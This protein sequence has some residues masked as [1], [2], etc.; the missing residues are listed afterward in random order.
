MPICQKCETKFPNR[1]R[2]DGKLKNLSSRKMCLDCSPWGQRNRRSAKNLS[3]LEAGV[4]VCGKCREE[5]DLADFYTS[6]GKR[7]CYCKD[8]EKTRLTERNRKLKLAAVQYKGSSCAACGYAECPAAMD[9]H[10]TD[11]NG[12]DFA[13]GRYRK[14]GI[15][16]DGAL[17]DTVKRELD[18]CT[19]LCC[20]CHREVHVGFREMS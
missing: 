11:P 16:K 13:L 1:V 3:D 9:F 18:K 14:A 17:T 10:H 12:K 19:L 5:R 6:N 8:C 15:T 20:R 4:A 2:I 7:A